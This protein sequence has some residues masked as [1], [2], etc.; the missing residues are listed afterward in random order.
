MQA[1]SSSQPEL[2]LGNH[3]GFKASEA[4]KNLM[5]A[6]FPTTWEKWN[7]GTAPRAG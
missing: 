3:I 1:L 2:Q 4:I 7:L 5:L 6:K